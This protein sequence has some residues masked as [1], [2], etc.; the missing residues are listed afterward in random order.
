[1]PITAPRESA[2]ASNDTRLLTEGRN[3]PLAMPYS[4][5]ADHTI[6]SFTASAKI[7]KEID[8]P[9]TANTATGFSPNRRVSGP[10][11]PA[12]PKAENSASTMKCS[13]ISRKS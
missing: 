2:S 5:N 8:A 11:K 1:M 3:K 9:M 12:C 6:A 7:T 13:P 4:T 10:I